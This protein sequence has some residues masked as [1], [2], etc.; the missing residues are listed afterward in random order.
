MDFRDAH[1]VITLPNP[2]HQGRGYDMLPLP[3]VGEG[4]GEGDFRKN[5]E[6]LQNE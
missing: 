5:K 2:S 1:H 4:W 6:N 3:S